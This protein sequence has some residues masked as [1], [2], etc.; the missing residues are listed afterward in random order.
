MKRYDYGPTSPPFTGTITV[1]TNV[2][3]VVSVLGLQS[4][5][6]HYLVIFSSAVRFSVGKVLWWI[7]V[8]CPAIHLLKGKYIDDTS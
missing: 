2:H 1:I 5:Y 4:G 3:C 8:Q 7:D 6:F